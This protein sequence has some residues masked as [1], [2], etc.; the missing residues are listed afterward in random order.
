MLDNDCQ[1]VSEVASREYRG[2]L[3]GSLDEQL[4]LSSV[5]KKQKGRNIARTTKSMNDK[6]EAGNQDT[7]GSVY[8]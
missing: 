2:W 8:N 6:G 7:I 3:P 4:Y 5:Y 1:S